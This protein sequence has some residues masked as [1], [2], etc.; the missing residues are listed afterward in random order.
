MTQEIG[1]SPAEQSIVFN[2]HWNET[3]KQTGISQ[4]ITAN[5][6]VLLALY[7]PGPAQKRQIR[8]G[9]PEHDLKV[10]SWTNTS[11]PGDVICTNVYDAANC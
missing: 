10:T 5:K 7:N 9:V 11:I 8:I 2:I 3:A 1:E 4:K 6:T